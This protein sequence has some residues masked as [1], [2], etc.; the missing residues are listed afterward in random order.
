ME[1]SSF[2]AIS[3]IV[4]ITSGIQDP[5]SVYAKPDG[6][7]DACDPVYKIACYPVSNPYKL[8]EEMAKSIDFANEEI[9]KQYLSSNWNKGLPRVANSGISFDS[10][11]EDF[12]DLNKRFTKALQSRY[13][14][15]ASEIGKTLKSS[16]VTGVS[17]KWVSPVTCQ[18]MFLQELPPRMASRGGLPS[19]EQWLQQRLLLARQASV[20]HQTDVTSAAPESKMPNIGS[21]NIGDKGMIA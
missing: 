19:Y 13:R 6:A 8:S 14:E 3:S 17:I 1:G 10:D 11:V 5:S 4:F 7:W 15:T 12:K 20:S 9:T 21:L 18:S 16:G 2:G